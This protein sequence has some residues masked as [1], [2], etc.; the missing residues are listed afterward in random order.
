MYRK[1]C[2]E[3]ILLINSFSIS[4]IFIYLQA[5]RIILH[6]NKMLKCCAGDDMPQITLSVALDLYKCGTRVHSIRHNRKPP[7]HLS[8]LLYLFWTWLRSN[9]RVIHDLTKTVPI[10]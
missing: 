6:Y 1:N 4:K 9:P 7:T 10:N 5:S 3:V 2:H 8:H